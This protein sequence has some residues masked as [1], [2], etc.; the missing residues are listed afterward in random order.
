MIK[1]M[2]RTKI[3][4]TS[5]SPFASPVILVKKKDSTWRL[6]VDYRALNKLTIKDK[7]LIPMIEELLEEL[8]GASVFSKIDLRSGYHQIR[9]ARGEEFKTAFRTH[10][11]HYEFL[12]MPFGLTNAPTTFQS[13]MNE[14][15]REHLRKFILVFF[16]DILVYSHT[17]TEH[18][19]HLA[20]V[21]NLLREHHLV[22]KASKCFFGRDQVEYLGHIISKQGVATD[23]YKIQAIREWPLP[24]GLKQLRGFLGLTGYYRRFV[25]GYG[26]ICK[27]LTQL[28]KKKAEGWND[29]ATTAFNQLK[30]IMTSAPVLALAD[31]NK[32]FIVETD[33]SII[34]VGAVLMQEGHPIA[35]ISKSLGP[36]QQVMSVYEREMLAILHAV[37]K[38]KHYL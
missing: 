35:F 29:A 37:T 28:L 1:E 7:Y 34:G 10:S 18:Y 15:F 14:I 23:P 16:D 8:V 17:L 27:P 20:T 26:S 22:A 12:V 24:I 13:L 6:C 32:T 4:R 31:F 30:R 3:I 19:E 38:W 21:L 33:A 36:K 5:N 2:L 11:G 25:R 9:M